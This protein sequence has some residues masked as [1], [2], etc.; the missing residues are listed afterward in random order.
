[1]AA[2]TNLVDCLKNIKLKHLLFRYF[3]RTKIVRVP[4]CMIKK[5]KNKKILVFNFSIL[6]TGTDINV[7]GLL[8]DSTH[9]LDLVKIPIKNCNL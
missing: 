7:T 2:L 8:G 5:T 6:E 3:H 9:F 1:M 4:N